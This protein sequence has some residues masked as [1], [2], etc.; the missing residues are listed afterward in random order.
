M[1]TILERLY[2]DEWEIICKFCGVKPEHRQDLRQE[3]SLYILEHPP[4]LQ[5]DAGNYLI[6]ITKRQYWSR[7]SRW[8]KKERRWQE[9]A[10]RLSAFGTEIPEPGE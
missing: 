6:A 1:Q 10:V 4:K 7:N 8:W 3:I 9:A 5:K 2:S